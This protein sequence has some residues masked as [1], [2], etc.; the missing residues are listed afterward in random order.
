MDGT[1]DVAMPRVDSIS[2]PILGDSLKQVFEE[3]HLQSPLT[4]ADKLEGMADELE[5]KLAEKARQQA[6]RCWQL[7]FSEPA[8]E[9]SSLSP[10][11]SL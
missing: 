6:K 5:D 11:C 8:I 3:T 2:S 7:N 10:F 1:P 4:T 9:A